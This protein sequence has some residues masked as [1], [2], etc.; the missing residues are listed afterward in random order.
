MKKKD[1]KLI[2]MPEIQ[3]RRIHLVGDWEFIV[4]IMI[5]SVFF[6]VSNFFIKNW[7]VGM[8][9]GILYGLTIN[10]IVKE[11]DIHLEAGKEYETT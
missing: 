4:P 11:I 2:F 3:K 6:F 1:E 8:A 9:T 7:I 5:I 10:W